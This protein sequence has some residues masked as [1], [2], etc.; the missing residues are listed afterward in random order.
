MSRFSNTFSLCLMLFLVVSCGSDE[1][2]QK[3][4]LT[5]LQE[6]KALEEQDAF[7]E[8][9][10]KVDSAIALAPID[11][12]VLRQGTSLKR[13]I[14][15]QEAN[16]R[17][18]EIQKELSL[19]AQQTPKLIKTFDKI[20]NKYYATDLRYQSPYFTALDKGEKSCLRMRLDSLGGIHIASIYVGRKPIKH[21]LIELRVP[22]GEAN[23]RSQSIA[24]DKALNY[25]FDVGSKHWEIVN[26]GEQDSRAIAKFLQKTIAEAPAK[27]LEL[28][29]LN[30]EKSKYKLR[31]DKNYYSAINKS[32]ELYDL[33]YKRDSL[34]RQEAKFARRF[35]RLNK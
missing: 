23:Y 11:T 1:N 26:Y 35:V 27:P 21:T 15:L 4:A 10:A 20:E 8:A 34:R 33:L 12:A 32:L 30:G 6:A 13:H 2:K 5:I 25:R 18:L 16:D 31:L 22:K 7:A 3:E 14:Y 19:I 28:H 24:Y 9:I 29:Y 17:L